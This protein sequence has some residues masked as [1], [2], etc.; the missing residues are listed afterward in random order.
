[1]VDGRVRNQCEHVMSTTNPEGKATVYPSTDDVQHYL[2]VL[3]PEHGF[4]LV[5]REGRAE[6]EARSLSLRG[7][8]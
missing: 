1:M 2:M 5:R 8:V 7:G 3:H 4:A 6:A